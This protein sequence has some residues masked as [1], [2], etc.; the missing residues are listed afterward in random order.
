MCMLTLLL[1]IASLPAQQITLI[2]SLESTLEQAEDRDTGFVN[3][4]NQLGYE[5]WIVDPSQSIER[6]NQALSLAEELKYAQ[7]QAFALR[8]IGV[9]YWAKG[10]AELAFRHLIAAKRIYEQLKDPLG[11]ANS[12]LNIGMVYA[13]QRDF[14]KADQSY[15]AALNTFQR[16]EVPSRI[17]TTY[18]KLADLLI[19]QDKHDAAF[20]Y[21]RRALEIHEA[22]DFTY[23]IGEANAKLGRISLATGDPDNAISHFLLAVKAGGQRFDHV[24]IAENF[25]GIGQAYL[26]KNQFLQA[27]DYLDRAENI[28]KAFG[29]L[30]VKY[31]VYAAQQELA[32]KQGN[33]RKALSYA[34]RKEAASDSLY[35]EETTNLMANYGASSRFKEQ[36]EKLELAQAKLELLEQQRRIDR[37]TRWLL[38]AG[39][40]FISGLAYFLIQIKNDTL[41][42]KQED[43]E[44]SEIRTDQLADELRDRDRELTTF[45]L[46]LAQRSESITNL[47]LELDTL[48]RKAPRDLRGE[49]GKLSRRVANI[50]DG[51]QEWENFQRYFDAAHPDLIKRLKTTYPDLTQNEFRLISLLRLNLTTKEMGSILGISPDSVKTARYRLRRKLDLPA[52]TKLYDF[53]LSIGQQL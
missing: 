25:A 19:L 17:A 27:S 44:A 52:S 9:G 21:L 11:R 15:T 14:D 47:K 28:A 49:I 38:L 5:Y 42:R 10:N 26:K 33:Y 34:E 36:E 53:L 22:N 35:T 6:G 23:G 40:V 16:L 2:D 4:L 48:R 41:H 46:N 50:A 51:A 37:L 8:V 1:G 3:L 39:L 24:G 13:D 31:E 45:T 12:D 20:N 30:K 18:T 7:G 29:L 43:L 32:T